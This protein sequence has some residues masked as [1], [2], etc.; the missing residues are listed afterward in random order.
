MSQ[1]RVTEAFVSAAEIAEIL[2]MPASNV[3][4]TMERAGFPFQTL[5]VGKREMKVYLRDHVELVRQ[6]REAK[7]QKKAAK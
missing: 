1:R 4:K 2:G 5:T 3:A 7:A 6:T